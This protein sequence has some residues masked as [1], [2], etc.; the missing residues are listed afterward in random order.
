MKSIKRLFEKIAKENPSWGSVVVF[1]HI[2]NGKNFTHDRIGRTFN[3]LVDQNEYLK[4]EK[5]GLLKYLYLVNTPLNRTK[6]GGILPRR[7]EKIPKMAKDTAD[8]NQAV[9]LHKIYG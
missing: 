1:N 2:V 6:N 9:K 7:D 5:K 3:E 4:S 8:I